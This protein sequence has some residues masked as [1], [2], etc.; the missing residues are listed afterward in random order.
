VSHC[1]FII[2][3]WK[4][5][6]IYFFATNV[7]AGE[8]S[9]MWGS[10]TTQSLV[11]H[12]ITSQCLLSSL[13]SKLWHPALEDAASCEISAVIHFP[14]TKNM[15]AT[16]ILN[17]L[18]TVYG[19]KAMSKGNVRQWCRMSKKMANQSSRRVKWWA[20]CTEWWSCP[21]DLTALEKEAFKWGS[22]VILVN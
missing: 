20:I 19:Q 2:V 11:N 7:E 1:H 6:I 12:R 9:H 5:I 22:N 8:R 14:H 18:S 21:D 17:E 4:V 16:E 15:S 13:R 10:I 3:I